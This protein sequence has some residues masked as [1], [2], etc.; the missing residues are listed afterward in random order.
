[1]EARHAALLHG[2]LPLRGGAMLPTKELRTLA[3]AGGP[4]PRHFPV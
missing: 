1:M 2:L 4:E 3:A